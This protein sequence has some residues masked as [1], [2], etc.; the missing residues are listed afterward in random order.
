MAEEADGVIE[1][2]GGQLRIALMTA[3]QIAEKFARLREDLARQQQARTEQ[4]TRELRVRF[5]AERDAARAA[6]APT[7]RPEWWATA[8]V[9]DIAE[10][11][12]TAHAWE[13]VDEDLAQRAAHMRDEVQERY[14]VDVD[15]ANVTGG[16]DTLRAALSVAAE[17]A[18]QQHPA[19]EDPMR[20]ML[21]DLEA[22]RA[23]ARKTVDPVYQDEW[24]QQASVDDIAAAYEAAHAWEDTDTDIAAHAQ[25]MRYEIQSRYGLD[26]AAMHDR[27]E[28]LAPAIADVRREQ[29]P[30]PVRDAMRAFDAERDAART[31]VSAAG[32]PKWWESST[33]E[34]IAATYETAAAWEAVDPELARTAE[35]MRTELRDRYG[36]DNP[37]AGQSAL[38]EALERDERTRGDAGHQRSESG[39]DVVEAGALMATADRLDREGERRDREQHER[40]Q[41][42]V[43]GV[44]DSDQALVGRGD[45]SAEHT[46]SDAYR[47]A[48]EDAYDSAERREAWADDMESEGLTADQV[49]GRIAADRNQATHPREAVRTKPRTSKGRGKGQS[50]G[51]QRERGGLSR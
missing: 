12:E 20:R 4:Q 37:Q 47:D 18:E 44:H 8:T 42:A 16:D 36:V 24:W 38:R 46:E 17:R 50:Q 21:T 48:G 34:Q 6:V 1:E 7:S 51:M 2:A 22:G 40:D 35:Q 41:A 26:V 32:D 33:P 30:S 28:A 3:T 11:Y 19:A 45:G 13:P 25:Q 23:D 15:G 14:G 31:E 49:Q 27:P 10:A 9:D 39:I 43:T 29:E 5:D